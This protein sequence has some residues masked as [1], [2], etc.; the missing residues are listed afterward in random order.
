V[1]EYANYV[2]KFMWQLCGQDSVDTS[3][4]VHSLGILKIVKSMCND[5]T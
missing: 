3:L 2:R 4:P 5:T 1:D